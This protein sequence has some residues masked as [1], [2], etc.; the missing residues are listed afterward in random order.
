[1]QKLDTEHEKISSITFAV[2]GECKLLCLWG[3][4]Y[5]AD[6]QLVL[7]TPPVKF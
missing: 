7:Q 2:C 6:L 4:L 5:L 3:H 1:M